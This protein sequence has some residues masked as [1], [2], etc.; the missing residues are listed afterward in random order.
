MGEVN[1]ALSHRISEEHQHCGTTQVKEH[2]PKELETIKLSEKDLRLRKPNLV[3][4]MVL[5]VCVFSYLEHVLEAQS[6]LE[7]S[8]FWG[9]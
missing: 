5:P 7:H 4:R 8:L 9:Q 1:S 6:V 3:H 2:T